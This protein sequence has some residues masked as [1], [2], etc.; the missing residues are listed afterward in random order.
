MALAL[1]K[2]GTRKSVTL[3]VTV[4]D[5]AKEELKRILE[6]RTLAPGKLLRLAGI[7]DR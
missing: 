2:A 4:T 3:M 5:K 1:V 7:V 6:T